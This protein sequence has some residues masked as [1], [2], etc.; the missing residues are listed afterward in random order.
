MGLIAELNGLQARHGYLRDTDMKELAGRLRLPLYRLQEVASFYPHFRAT[1]P[2]RVEIS[3]CRDLCCFLAGGERWN[4]K[5]KE[6]LKGQPD[7]EV[8][9]VSCLGRCEKAPA[10]LVNGQAVGGES[11]ERIAELSR[12]P[13]PPASREPAPERRWRLDPYDTGSEPFSVAKYVICNADESEPGTFK[14]RVILEEL[15]HLVI[16][17]MCIAATVVGAR[18]GW[19]YLRHEYEHV[20]LALERAMDR[21]RSLGLLGRDF[22]VEIFLSPGGYIMGEETALLEALEEKRGEP[23]NK[24][25]FPGTRGLWGKPTLVNN[26]ETLAMIPVILKRGAD[27]WKAQGVR[28]HHGLKVMAVS[29][30]VARPGVYEIGLGTTVAELIEMAGGVSGG[31]R[32]K[33]FTPGGASSNFLPAEQVHVEI[34]FASIQAAGSMLG[35]GALVVIAEGTEM[36]SLA[37]NVARFFRNESC[38]KCVPC[39]VGT[40]KVVKMLDDILAGNGNG[41][42]LE[43]L[44]GLEETLALTSICGL[45]QVALNPLTS[46]LRHW[47]EEVKRHLARSQKL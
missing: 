35:S 27:W 36:L 37:A 29:G 31:R 2:P 20:C 34:D 23:R 1:P 15:P 12:K 5:V 4:A 32:L 18:R 25:P 9:E 21:A 33:A 6:L 7:T 16:E 40:E 19:I 17:G 10:A 26:V 38:G 43:I 30:H 45:G 22:D 8:R 11:A 46:V 39:R 13:E 41:V 14:D 3:L 28:G 47:P 44:P 24:P 42:L